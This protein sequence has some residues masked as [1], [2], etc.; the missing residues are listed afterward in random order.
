MCFYNL[1]TLGHLL[2]H[3][4]VYFVYLVT[5]LGQFV[6]KVCIADFRLTQSQGDR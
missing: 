2:D 3:Q 1:H 6:L 5:Q 4:V